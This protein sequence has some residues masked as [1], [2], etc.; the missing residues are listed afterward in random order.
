M[1]LL[2]VYYKESL[3]PDFSLNLNKGRAVL[4][5]KRS[6]GLKVGQRRRLLRRRDP[7]AQL[8]GRNRRRPRLDGRGTGHRGRRP[9]SLLRIRLCGLRH[10][11][12][13]D[14]ADH[15]SNFF[16]G[17]LFS[18]RLSEALEPLPPAEPRPRGEKAAALRQG[19]A[20]VE[21]F[22]IPTL[23]TA[24]DGVVVAGADARMEARGTT[25]T[26]SAGLSGSAGT[27]AR[28]GPTWT[29]PSTSAARAGQTAPPPSTVP[30]STTGRKA[31]ST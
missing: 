12:P 18:L 1:T 9:G 30:S 26:T 21:N 31:C 20:G 16:R 10:C 7:P 28:P 24:G 27:A 11:G 3:L 17:E 5:A 14:M 4:T 19:M 15:Y 6:G 22:R 8:P 13:G 2:A 25:P 29:Y 23:L